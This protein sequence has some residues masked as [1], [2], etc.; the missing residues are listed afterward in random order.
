MAHTHDVYDMENHFEINGSSRFIKETSVTKLVV[1]Q[2]DHK[3]E[4]LTFKM[5]RYIDGHD[6]TLCNKI[7]I[8]YINLD[9]K[10]NNKSADVYEVTDLTL[11]EECED[12]LTFTW[13]IEAPATK[14]SGTLSF[15]VKFEC[16]EGENVLYQWNTAKYVS[17]NVLAGIDN[18]EEFVEKYSNVL[19]EWYNE[20]TKGADSIE[21]LNQQ[22]IAEIELA[23]EDAKEDIQGKADATMAEMNQFSSNAYNSFKNDVDEKAARTLASIPEEY[24]DLDAEVKENSS[25]LH[26][27]IEFDTSNLISGKFISGETGGAATYSNYYCTD[28]L[29]IV[30]STKI[31]V[32]NAT[33]AVADM[34]GLAFYDKEQKFISGYRYPASTEVFE[35]DVPDESEYVRFTVLYPETFSAEYVDILTPFSVIR[36]SIGKQEEKLDTFDKIDYGEIVVG[37]FISH[38]SGNA[39]VYSAGTY[40]HTDYIAIAQKTVINLQNVTDKSLNAKGLA[41]YD[42]AK[43]YISGY[44]YPANAETISVD[45]PE[46]TVWMRFTTINGKTPLVYYEKISDAV[47][48]LA[49]RGA[50]IGI[51]HNTF[52]GNN[53]TENPLEKIVLH[54]D[55]IDLFT[56]VGCIGD[57]L[58]SGVC[59]YKDSSGTHYATM[60][61]YSWCK[62][63]ERMTGNTYYCWAT[64]GFTTNSWLSSDWATECFDG[65]HLCTA[66][67]IGLGQNDSNSNVSVGTSA[68]I[69]LEDYTQNPNSF[70]GN[71]G[72]IIQKIKEV[73]PKAKIFVITDPKAAMETGGYNSAIRD[74]ATIFEN[75]YI[76]DM[77]THG[78]DLFNNGLIKSCLRYSHYNALGYKIIASV[79]ATYIDWIVKKHSSEFMEVEF[80][81]TD[82]NYN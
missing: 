72:K 23:K 10:T 51:E 14:Y 21:E 58:A 24:T 47:Q 63:L 37:S 69:N 60:R 1:V 55:M 66:Y 62:F 12:V 16:T 29:K 44:Q 74:M 81:G 31:Q 3:S 67:I 41:F 13:T 79:I 80:I 49:E 70:Y 71:Y 7:R 82:Y 15:L 33:N 30:G 59:A 5:P 27:I 46:N 50:T 77:Y 68:D 78:S 22:A 57:S 35:V 17:V 39:V 11:C 28:F 38:T 9:T 6:M 34:K 73:N 19:E 36:E 32:K 64:G 75:V 54:P 2:G 4:V 48:G 8:H 42:G 26:N 76:I 65:N 25:S 20:L 40:N 56:T 53:M 45:V 43:N 18:S 52:F 61:E